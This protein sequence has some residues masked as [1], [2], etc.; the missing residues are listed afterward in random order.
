M[1]LLTFAIDRDSVCA[2]DDSDPHGAALTLSSAASLR[3][4]IA[5]ARSVCP[6]ARIAGGQATWLVEIGAP[7]RCIAVIAQQ[8]DAPRLLL[9]D[10]AVGDLFTGQACSLYFRYR[11]QID[12]QAEFDALRAAASPPR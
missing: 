1:A 12:P 10:S 9:D 2:G 11:A 3:E 7:K 5:A 6:L 8:W 4:L